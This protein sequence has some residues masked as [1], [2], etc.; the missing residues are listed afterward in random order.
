MLLLSA[1]V[2]IVYI[3]IPALFIA[4]AMDDDGNPVPPEL[5]NEIADYGYLVCGAFL[6]Y[7]LLV[8]CVNRLRAAGLSWWKLLVPGYNVYVLFTAPDLP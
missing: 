3:G 5:T 7:V 2:I 4:G 6:V 1:M 8:T